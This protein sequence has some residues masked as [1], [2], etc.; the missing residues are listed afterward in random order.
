MTIEEICRLLSTGFV[1]SRDVP[2]LDDEATRTEV[3]RRADAVGQRLFYSSNA[4]TYGFVMAG[5]L[6][7]APSHRP[8]IRL[9]RS[10]RA[11]IAVCWMHLRWLPAERARLVEGNG[12]SPSPGE[13]S[14]T[15]DDLA[16]QLKGQMT[17]SHLDQKIVPH[18][19]HT[20][21]LE[22][23]D[24]RLY[25]G[26]MLDSLD[27]LK[28]TELA[29]ENMLRFKRVAHL[30]QRADEIE[31]IRRSGEEDTRASD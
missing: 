5:E 3:Q 27:E 17:K 24:H 4:D 13:P 22:A 6:P 25:A 29:R 21:Y 19:K 7:D 30:R 9:D 16:Y 2:E 18:L 8:A 11:V 26:P 1:A 20:G 10:H 14:I 28:A 23:R 12:H 31:R 15:I